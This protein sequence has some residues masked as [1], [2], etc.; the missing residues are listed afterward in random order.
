MLLTFCIVFNYRVRAIK[1]FQFSF[2][3]YNKNIVQRYYGI[4][5]NIRMRIKFRQC[6]QNINFKKK[7]KFIHS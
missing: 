4:Q 7:F 2:Y 5:L 3:S 6:I 1:N